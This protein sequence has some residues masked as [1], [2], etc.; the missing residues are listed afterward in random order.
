MQTFH[1]NINTSL[2][3]IEIW[4][5]ELFFSEFVQCNL[6]SFL[7]PDGRLII[8]LFKYISGRICAFFKDRRNP[9]TDVISFASMKL[10][11][12]SVIMSMV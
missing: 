5:D 8:S 6:Y 10:Q 1:T 4:D 3:S 11:E 2:Y 12:P 7:H 9:R